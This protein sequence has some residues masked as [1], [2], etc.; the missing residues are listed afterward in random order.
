MSQLQ[1]LGR[2]LDNL[3]QGI[4]EVLPHLESQIFGIIHP[5]FVELINT[6]IPPQYEQEV[7]NILLQRVSNIKS[8]YEGLLEQIT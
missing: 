8:K 6:G 1:A 4:K 2:S 5:T 7:L 3:L